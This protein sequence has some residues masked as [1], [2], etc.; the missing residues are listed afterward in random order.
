MQM[1]RRTFA[2][3]VLAATQVGTIP[4]LA[5][6]P[7][8]GPNVIIVRFGGGVRRRETIEPGTTYAPVLLN[9]LAPR[10]VLIPRLSIAQLD[11]VDTSHSEGTLNILTGRYKA[12]RNLA[13]GAKLDRLEPTEPTLFEVFRRTYDIPEHQA[14]LVNGE[15][16]LQEEYLTYGVHPSHGVAYKSEVLS[17]YRFKLWALREALAEG[18][19][20]DA[21]IGAQIEQLAE[22]EAKGMRGT[23]LRQAPEIE[24]MWRRWRD[25]YGT[26]GLKNPRGDAALT[27]LAVWALR[28]LRPRLMMINYQDPDYVHWGNASHYGRAIARIDH[29]LERLVQT[30]E[31]DPDYAGRTIFCVVPDCGRDSNPLTRVPF[32]HHFNSRSAHEIFGLVFGP[33]IVAGSVLDRPVDQSAVAPTLAA[34][35]GMRAER[36]EGDVLEEIF[37]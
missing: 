6:R 11:G 28:D 9:R 31:A 20:T 35:M 36:A 16:R 8:S 18:A 19:G 27:E 22:L 1:D 29:D 37:A 23:A 25:F 15:D 2:A 32:Q 5:A 30:V 24:A 12:Y 33:G 10:G 14:L 4:A 17:L 3:G 34:A 26:T 13:E 21:E 7:Y